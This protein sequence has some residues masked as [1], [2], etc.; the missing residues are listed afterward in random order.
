M[1]REQFPYSGEDENI[2]L[3]AQVNAFCEIS[4][5]SFDP[6]IHPPIAKELVEKIDPRVKSSSSME[7]SFSGKRRGHIIRG[8]TEHGEISV[9]T[10]GHT[11]DKSI[12]KREY[13]IGNYVVKKYDVG[14]HKSVL[15][16]EHFWKREPGSR[17]SDEPSPLRTIT[18]NIKD[19]E[20]TKITI[21][22]P[23]LKRVRIGSAKFSMTLPHK[24][25]LWKKS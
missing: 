22:T 1:T 13:R 9:P 2:T 19:L 21:V 25:M 20:P 6:A 5:D 4:P 16:F 24:T 7:L 18:Y 12:G 17:V 10:G 3:A 23:K 15:I 8:A 14:L 11:F